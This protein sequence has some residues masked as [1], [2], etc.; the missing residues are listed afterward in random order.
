MVRF[1]H[2]DPDLFEGIRF[3]APTC[4]E[5]SPEATAALLEQLISGQAPAPECRALPVLLNQRSMNKTTGSHNFATRGQ[6]NQFSIE[7]G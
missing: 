3:L 7:P 4:K 6:A 5:L 2:S 1:G